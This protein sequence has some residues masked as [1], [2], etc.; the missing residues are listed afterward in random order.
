MTPASRRVSLAGR[1]A[2]QCRGQVS[3]EWA[4]PNGPH[5]SL[6]IEDKQVA[7]FEG[8]HGL[9]YPLGS[10]VEVA[11]ESDA[12]HLSRLLHATVA[13]LEL[14][15]T[16]GQVWIH[17]YVEGALV[18]ELLYSDGAWQIV[19]GE[20]FE[21]EDHKALKRWL[22]RK[23]ILPDDAGERIFEALLGQGFVCSGVVESSRLRVDITPD[24]F[25]AEEDAVQRASA[26][27]AARFAEASR[28]NEWVMYLLA[29]ARHRWAK[30]LLPAPVEYPSWV[31]CTVDAGPS[32]VSMIADCTVVAVKSVKIANHFSASV[33]S[34]EHLLRL[35]S[36]QNGSW[37]TDGEPCAFE[38]Q[39]A[40]A[41]SLSSPGA[42]EL[43]SLTRAVLGTRHPIGPRFEPEQVLQVLT[44][45][46]VR[47]RD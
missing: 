12:R 39:S 13:E 25:R 26:E 19:M 5:A 40:V 36:W 41:R 14:Q 35:L 3:L 22:S 23:R 20:A 47:R 31:P 15:T 24:E 28:Q 42:P 38:D 43:T 11:G 34:G 21:F 17:G 33:F 37:I 4:S 8:H 32:F 44:R 30:P 27:A 2:F 18:R 16:V 9:E 45:R 1:P 29:E 46:F 6:R 7:W 10:W